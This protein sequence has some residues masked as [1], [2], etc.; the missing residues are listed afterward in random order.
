MNGRERKEK[1]TASF[2]LDNSD[3][4]SN[5]Q[6]IVVFRQLHVALLQSSW[7]DES[8]DL[9]A[10]DFVQFL[11]GGLDLAL[12]GLDIHNKHESVTVLDKFHGGFS[13]EGVFDNA[14]FIHR[15]FF[16]DAGT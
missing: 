10:L 9:L 8:V 7:G 13:G 3:S 5:I 6:C 14:V 4:I 12:I 11:D 15:T 1:F 16:R 2:I